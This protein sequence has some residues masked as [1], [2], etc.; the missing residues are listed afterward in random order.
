MK[1]L[2]DTHYTDASITYELTCFGNVGP[3]MVLTPTHYNV[4]VVIGYAC[5]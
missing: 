3:L 1:T 4:N 5:N 2:H